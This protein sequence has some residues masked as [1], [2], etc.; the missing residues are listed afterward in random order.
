MLAVPP[1]R[2]FRDTAGLSLRRHTQQLRARVAAD[3][4]GR[5]ARDLTELA[6][7]LG[8]ADDSQLTNAFRREWDC[9]RRV[10]GLWPVPVSPGKN[11]QAA[12]TWALL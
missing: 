7:D 8:Y 11:F 12:L 4:L 9:R 5:G 10:S 3:R 6:L 1:V 2:V